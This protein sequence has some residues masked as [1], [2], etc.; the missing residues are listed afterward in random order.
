MHRTKYTIEG[1]QS[2]NLESRDWVVTPGCLF[3]QEDYLCRDQTA[4]YYSVCTAQEPG[5]S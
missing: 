2:K 4:L 5:G 3:V 1:Q